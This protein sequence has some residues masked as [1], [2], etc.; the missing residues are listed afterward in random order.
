MALHRSSAYSGQFLLEIDGR[1]VGVLH[2]LEGGEP[3]GVVVPEAVIAGAPAR[4]HIAECKYSPLELF[5]GSG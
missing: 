4:K 5:S 1:I 3:Y 2:S